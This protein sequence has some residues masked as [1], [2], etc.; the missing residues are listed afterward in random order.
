M[1]EPLLADPP[2]IVDESPLHHRNLPSGP[3]E[4]LQRDF[5]PRARR[6]AER[7]QVA[8]S[9]AL[10]AIG[11]GHRSTSATNTAYRQA[12]TIV[13]SDRESGC[14][15]FAQASMTWVAA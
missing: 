1:Q 15:L 10:P 14:A 8:A 9:S 6:F 3:A 12:R 11:Q 5:E 2:T 4:G 13:A 7:N